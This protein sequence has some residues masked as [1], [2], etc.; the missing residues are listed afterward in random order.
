MQRLQFDLGEQIS[1]KEYLKRK[2][3]NSRLLRKRSK[4][5]YMLLACFMGLIV[6]IS[7]Q[8]VQ[9][10]KYNSFKYIEGDGVNKQAV[11]SIIYVTEGYTYDPVYSVSTTLSSGEDEKS[12]LPAS[13]INNICTTPESLYGLKDGT[14][15]KITRDK[16]EVEELFSDNVKKFTISNNYVL[17][18]TKDEERLKSYNMENGEISSFDITNVKQILSTD[19]NVLAVT[20]THSEKSLYRFDFK[21]NGKEKISG[22]ERVSNAVIDKNTVYFVN[23]LDDDSIFKVDVDGNNLGK[24]ADI[25]GIETLNE[26]EIDGNGYMFVRNNTIYYVNS[27]D[28][29]TLWSYNLENG[30]SEKILSSPIELLGNID[31]TILYKVDNEMGIYLYNYDTKFMSLVTKRRIKEFVI[32]K[33]KDVKVVVE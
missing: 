16:Y 5:T 26:S 15:C 21:G 30:Q 27:K 10:N 14:V 1:R 3:K 7:I 32:D 18:I 13:G 28:D 17:Y 4:I 8:L 33:Y 22:D 29:D 19:S 20:S 31:D 11:Y 6:Y 24:V 25:H 9:Y 23:K 2:K 12:V